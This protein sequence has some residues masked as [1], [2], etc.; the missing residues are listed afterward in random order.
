MVECRVVDS[1][2][3]N[4]MKVAAAHVI[5]RAVVI[6]GAVI[7]V[8]TF[9]SHTAV[10]IAII[11][12]AIKADFCTPVA[13]VP[14]VATITPTPIAGSPEQANFGSHHPRARHPE[15]AF[16][17][18]GPIARRPYITVGGRHRLGV[19]RQCGRS[20]RDGHRELRER[21]GRYGQYEKCEQQQT[22]DTHFDYLGRSSFDCP[23]AF[24][25]CG[26][27]G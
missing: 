13:F 9:I 25:G 20:D 19:N 5:Y 22:D 14:G 10:A 11:H 7:P 17:A 27:R 18:I 23:V 1:S 12:A 26:L 8:A 4:I 3:I 24:R 21:C 16:I 6:E 2:A 15:V